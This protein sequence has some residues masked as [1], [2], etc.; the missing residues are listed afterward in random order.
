LPHARQLRRE[1]RRQPPAQPEGDQGHGECDPDQ[2][3]EQPR[4]IRRDAAAAPPAD[5]ALLESL[6]FVL[7]RRYGVVFRRLLAREA[8]CLP[9]WHV[10]LRALRRLEAQGQIRG[11]R[12]VAGVTGEQYAL[13]EAVGALR[14]VRRRAPERQWITLSAADPL[15]L[16]GIVTP[17]ARVPALAGNRLLLVDGVPAATS[18][19]GE[20]QWLVDFP[21]AEQWRARNALLRTTARS[22][23]VRAV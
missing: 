10:L 18:R 23:L 4:L 15:N 3:S 22:A 5:P 19:A 14:A 9:P 7:L 17:G 8:P 13:P 6:A 16:A 21:P 1:P 11:G 12:F 20:I 2:P